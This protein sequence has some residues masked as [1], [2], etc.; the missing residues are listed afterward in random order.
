M[1]VKTTKNKEFFYFIFGSYKDWPWSYVF[2]C[3]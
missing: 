1:Q 2:S 3:M